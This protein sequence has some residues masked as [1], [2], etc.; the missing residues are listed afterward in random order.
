MAISSA[1]PCIA[2]QNARAKAEGFPAFIVLF[3]CPASIS[4]ML[5]ETMS[6]RVRLWLPTH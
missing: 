3:F 5:E 4:G 1:T 6:I 2:A